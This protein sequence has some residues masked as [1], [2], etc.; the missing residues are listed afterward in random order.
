MGKYIRHPKTGQIVRK[1]TTVYLPVC[2]VQIRSRYQRALL[3][4][5][6]GLIL[7]R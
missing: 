5:I 7:C 6:P 4:R 1:S 3:G 2:R